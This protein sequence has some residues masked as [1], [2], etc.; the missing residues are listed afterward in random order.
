MGGLRR[1]TPTIS[2]TVAF[3][4]REARCYHLLF[5]GTELQEWGW[6]DPTELAE[7]VRAWLRGRANA[8]LGDLVPYLV[9]RGEAVT[10]STMPRPAGPALPPLLAHQAIDVATRERL[11]HATHVLRVEAANPPAPTVGFP[12]LWCAFAVAATTAAGAGAVWFDVGALRVRST[13]ATNDPLNGDGVVHLGDHL[14][15]LQSRDADGDVQTTTKGMAAFGLPEL[16]LDGVP[17][18]LGGVAALLVQGVGQRLVDGLVDEA[19]ASGAPRVDVPV[20]VVVTGAH[21]ARAA[22][23]ALVRELGTTRVRL[24]YRPADGTSDDDHLV[25]TPGD[26]ARRSAAEWLTQVAAELLTARSTPMQTVAA[27]TPALDEAHARA[28]ARLAD[29]RRAAESARPG[30]LVFVKRGFPT[31]AG[32]TEYLW[33]VVEA[34]DEA[35]IRGRLANEPAEAVGVVA[36]QTIELG[37]DEVFDWL[38]TRDGRRVAGGWSI[39]ALP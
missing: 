39:D 37:E 10:V 16:L 27:A 8:H 24:S 29:A 9:D 28:V 11:A 25:V 15:L 34:W 18:H 31:T 30:E 35:G 26:D 23:G 20:E 38:Q 13:A 4:A 19:H 5:G 12:G 1:K 36:G 7:R 21:V 33:I 3:P 14:L 6:L 22:E 17:G 32:S 2:G